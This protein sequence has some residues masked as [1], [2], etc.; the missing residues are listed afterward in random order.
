MNKN[1]IYLLLCV[2]FFCVSIYV[3]TFLHF[4]DTSSSSTSNLPYVNGLITCV[5]IILMSI[6]IAFFTLYFHNSGVID[7]K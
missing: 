5:G 4:P 2:L 7:K 6:S 1:Y 3:F